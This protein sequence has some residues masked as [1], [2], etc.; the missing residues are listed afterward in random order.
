MGLTTLM[1]QFSRRQTGNKLYLLNAAKKKLGE[2]RKLEWL[3]QMQ[4]RKEMPADL[5]PEQVRKLLRIPGAI[6]KPN[7]PEEKRVITKENS[8][9]GYFQIEL[10]RSSIGMPPKS[11]DAI[12]CLGLR[13]R[14]SVAFHRQTPL[15]AGNILKVKELLRVTNVEEPINLRETRRPKPGFR[16][17]GT[18]MEDCTI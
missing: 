5:E 13:K 4:A 12:R 6:P 11:R 14:G 17:V 10:V 15:I 2:E 1:R 9:T 16:V 3:Q 8:G 18:K 7:M